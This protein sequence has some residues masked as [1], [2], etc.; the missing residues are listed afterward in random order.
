MYSPVV[1]DR[2]EEEVM[3][4]AHAIRLERPVDAIVAETRVGGGDGLASSVRVVA[5]RTRTSER[6]KG[7]ARNEC[8]TAAATKR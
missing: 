2:Q 5:G 1:D 3:C 4:V 8:D 6:A 7:R